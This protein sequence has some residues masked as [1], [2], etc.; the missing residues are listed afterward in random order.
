MRL[1]KTYDKTKILGLWTAVC[2][3]LLLLI[4]FPTECRN[5]AANGVFL[6]IQVLIPSLFPFMVLSGFVV[7]SGLSSRI[8]RV[9]KKAV[10]VLFGLPGDAA[11]VILLSLVGGYP[12]GAKGIN[13]LYKEKLISESQAKRMAMFCVASGPGFL[14]TYLG[15]AMLGNTSVGY[16]LLS[17][18]T[19]S[20]LILGVLARF[21]VKATLSDNNKNSKLREIRIPEALTISVR[22]GIRSCAGMCGLVVL[23]GTLCEVFLTLTENSP[24]L[25]G[26]A[27]LIEITMGTKILTE[28]YPTVLLSAAC[29]F[30]GLCVHFQVFQQLGDIKVPKC[31]FY[32]F[33]VLQ[34]ILS[35]V[36]TY[37]LLKIFPKSQEVFSTVAE[38]EPAMYS[39]IFGFL[40]LM[41]TC[42]AFLISIRNFKRY[43]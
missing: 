41:L 11:A 26:L 28:G 25:W 38:A 22:D 12:V 14:V 27:A 7:S 13:S 4:V 31:K 39:G 23:F 37:L 34:A 9:V 16:I 21:W 30:G 15:A 42:V 17:A 19:V 43:Q 3:I 20:V 29:G 24:E 33:R 32:I 2:M 5:G 6:C 1:Y 10:N 36:F 35:G 8:P 40:C 18:Q